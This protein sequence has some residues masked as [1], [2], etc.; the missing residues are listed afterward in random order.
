LLLVQA[1]FFEASLLG[2]HRCL[3]VRGVNRVQR[4]DL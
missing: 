1:I 2:R 4:A 3:Y